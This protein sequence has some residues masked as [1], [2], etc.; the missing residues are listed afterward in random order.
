MSTENV[1]FVRAAYDS[2]N[3]KR[4]LDLADVIHP[5]FE[6]HTRADVFAPP[7]PTVSAQVA[8]RATVMPIRSTAHP[9]PVPSRD[10]TR[11]PPLTDRC[12]EGAGCHEGDGGGAD[13]GAE[14]FE[15]RSPFTWRP[16]LRPLAVHPASR[17]MLGLDRAPA[18]G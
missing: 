18:G 14:H 11:R 15:A 6:W 10:Q 2:G 5:D 13:L 9:L 8:A 7:H 17:G 12:S 4:E 16:R 1:E 3:R